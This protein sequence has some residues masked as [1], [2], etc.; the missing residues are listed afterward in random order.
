MCFQVAAEAA[1]TEK[2]A[3]QEKE[4]LRAQDE[5]AQYVQALGTSQHREAELQHEVQALQARIVD[6]AIFH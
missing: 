5:V 6:G 4:L 1:S 2:I 3:A